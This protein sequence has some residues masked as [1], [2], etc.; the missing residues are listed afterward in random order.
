MYVHYAHYVRSNVYKF[1]QN[2]AL[3]C[4]RKKCFTAALLLLTKTETIKLYFCLIKIQIK[5]NY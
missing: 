4:H 1:R 3:L 5:Y 2:V